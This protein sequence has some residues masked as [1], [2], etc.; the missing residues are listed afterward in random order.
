VHLIERIVGPLGLRV[1]ES[2]PWADAR[3]P[4]GSRVHAIIPPLSLRGPVLTIRKFSP[5]PITAEGLVADGSA[6][7]RMMRFLAACILGRMNV[8]VSGGADSDGRGTAN[9]VII[10][11]VRLARDAASFCK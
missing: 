8:V 9:P 1:D 6:G 5:V 7:P 2:S 11:K 10:H 4:E 3:L